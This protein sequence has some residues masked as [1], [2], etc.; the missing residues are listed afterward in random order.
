M[1]VGR[2]LMLAITRTNCVDDGIF[3]YTEF[4]VEAKIMVKLK[5][6]DATKSLY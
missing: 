2:K 5:T 4:P 1:F 3:I 6:E